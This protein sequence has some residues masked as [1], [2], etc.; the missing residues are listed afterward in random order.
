MSPNGMSSAPPEFEPAQEPEPT[1]ELELTRDTAPTQDVA[2]LSAAKAPIGPG[3]ITGLGL[4]WSVLLIAIGVL[5]VQAALVAAGWLDGTSWLAWVIQQFDELTPQ[6]W[7]L[8]AGIV[9]ILLGLWLVLM[10]LR[11]RP[12]NAMALTASTG[13]F[14]KPADV[15]RIAVA[16]AEQVDGVEDA[17]ASAS[18][19]RV[20]LRIVG[21]GSSEIAGEVQR[22]VTERLSALDTPVRVSVRTTEGSS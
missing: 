9:L 20:S 12:S 5:G 16:A 2:P 11:P 17:K 21:T 10:A 18:R 8:P 4:V 19:G 22:A 6:W 13:V 15:A 14:V 3:T 1:Q 7:M